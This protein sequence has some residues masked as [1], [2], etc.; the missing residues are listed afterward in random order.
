VIVTSIPAAAARQI[1]VPREPFGV[2]AWSFGLWNG[3]F[4]VG[5]VCFGPPRR[6]DNLDC[7]VGDGYGVR[8]VQ[9]TRGWTLTHP[10]NACSE[11]ISKACSLFAAEHPD[12]RIVIAYTDPSQ[13]EHGAV[14]KASSWFYAG[15][16]CKRTGRTIKDIWVRWIGPP[17]EGKYWKGC[18]PL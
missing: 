3:P 10:P 9:L 4:L 12:Y 11:F 14:Y 7:I 18:R 5:A 16:T 17:L 1:I 6:G 8:T 13:G 15:K 2:S